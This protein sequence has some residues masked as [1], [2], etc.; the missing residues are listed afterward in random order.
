MSMV[1]SEIDNLTT[2]ESLTNTVHSPEQQRAADMVEAVAATELPSMSSGDSNDSI[3]FNSF[4]GS[5]ALLY[6]THITEQ[7]AKP[8]RSGSDI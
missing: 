1:D 8:A 5:I 2:L 3:N 7:G 6:V 4:P